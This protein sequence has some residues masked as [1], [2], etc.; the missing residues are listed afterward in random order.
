MGNIYSPA[1]NEKE[2]G[3]FI[4]NWLLKNSFNPRKYLINSDRFNIVA[5]EEGEGGGKDLI[6]NAHMETELSPEENK[7]SMVN[8]Q[9]ELYLKAWVEGNKIFGRSVL[10]DRG[11]MAVY[12]IACKAIKSS[13]IKLKGDLIQTMVVG[14]IGMV[15]VDEFKG[16]SYD[17]RY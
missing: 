7:W 9:E 6:F 13:G 17:R 16:L 8:P 3:N 2:M 5:T 14:E 1:G 4:Y 12:M 11:S 15:P 10:N